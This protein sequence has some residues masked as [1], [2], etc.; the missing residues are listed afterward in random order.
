MS[1]F[2]SRFFIPV[3]ILLSGCSP[4]ALANLAD[5]EVLDESESESTSSSGSSTTTTSVTTTTTSSGGGSTL[6]TSGGDSDAMSGV[7]TD[8]PPAAPPALVGYSLST[9]E[10][11]SESENQPLVIQENGPIHVYAE[12]T[13]ADGV[14]VELDDGAVIELVAEVAGVF[15]GELAVTSALANGNHTATI[16][17]FREGYGDG[18]PALGSYTVDLPVMGAELIWNV[19]KSLGKGWVADVEL[20]PNGDI[21]E[22]GTLTS[23]SSRSCFIR[24]RNPEG[25]SAPEEVVILLD[26]EQC[27]AVGLEVRGS[28]QLFVLATVEDEDGKRWWVGDMPGWKST[29]FP[30]AQGE[31]GE[32][33]TAFDLRADRTA[34]VCGTK[35]SG[36]GDL[37][38]FAAVLEPGEELVMRTFDYVPE[39]DGWDENGFSETPHDCLFVGDGLMVAGEA[40]GVHGEDAKEATARRFFLPVDLTAED[41]DDP[42]PFVVAAG[43]GPGN[44]TQSVATAADVDGLGRL[45]LSGYTCAEVPCSKE[46]QGYLWVH[47]PDGTLDWFTSLGLHDYPE[48]APIGVR[49]HPAGY[50]VVGSGGLEGEFTLRA[51]T[52]G[53][54]VPLWT[55]ARIDPFQVHFPVAVTIGPYGQIC[56]GGFG[57]GVYPGLACVGS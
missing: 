39:G 55:Y 13:H 22:F 9:N 57:S 44:A 53:D 25:A 3:T 14:R 50:A 27:E 11:E 17:P 20:L 24:R 7:S 18:E 21:I 42:P 29:I 40:Y 30:I 46:R 1:S 56:A 10:N 4:M 34:V 54:H 2:S 16:V 26:G 37:D 41:S 8:G 52:V 49:A 48:L 33:A 19:D 38:A 23:D 32:T 31:V 43:W 28:N 15:R 51:F 12:T 6:G 45:L 5:P 35:P 36:Y 47:H